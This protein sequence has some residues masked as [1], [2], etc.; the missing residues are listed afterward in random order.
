M[1]AD[2][3]LGAGPGRHDV[4]LVAA[5]RHDPVDPLG[6]SD[7]LAQRGHR[8]VAEHGGVERVAPLVGSGGGVG[9]APVVGGEHLLHG[10]GVD[11]RQLGPGRVD[12][13][14]RVD[15][16]EGA[17]SDE[18][19]LAAAALLGRR[20]DRAHPAAGLLGQ[21]RSGQAGAEA[22]GGDD[23]VPAGVADPR[24]GVVLAEHGDERPPA[25]G[26]GGEGG[27]DPVG[28][29]LDGQA[30]RLEDPRQQVVGEALL[31]VGLGVLV[32]LV[33]DVEE[34]LAAGL[35]LLPQPGL[36]LVEVHGLPPQDPCR[37]TILP[38]CW[39]ASSRSSAVG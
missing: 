30:G 24:Q 32:D 27:V 23:V 20:A 17:R 18:R 11:A 6:G 31:V 5:L 9:G 3:P 4:G 39:P 13:E 28:G 26:A 14:G 25:P 19:D 38:S 29:A 22:G 16:V 35:H 7:V 1:L 10:D 37:S 12:H 2:H 21:R 33:G 8:G 36:E 15:P 34:E